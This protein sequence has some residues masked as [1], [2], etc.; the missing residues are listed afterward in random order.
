MKALLIPNTIFHVYTHAV[1]SDNLFRD[2]DDYI[3]FLTTLP[4]HTRY[5]CDIQ[6]YCLM[7]NHFHLLIRICSKSELLERALFEDVKRINRIDKTRFMTDEELGR[8]L[9][10]CLGRAFSSHSQYVNKRY[11][12]M[13]NLFISNFKRK[14]ITD[15]EY[16]RNV[17]K[18]IHMNPV[19]HG[20]E[21]SPLNWAFSSYSYMRF[22]P[23]K[24]RED[25]D[26]LR[27][28]GGHSSFI[29]AHEDFKSGAGFSPD[30]NNKPIKKKDNEEDA[31]E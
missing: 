23:E 22:M 29:A 24:H 28:F 20:F 11:E 9:S 26:I 4:Y 8:F 16:H 13:G 31:N 30:Y 14:V 27:L 21:V 1:G 2:P 6:A 10:G 18:Y 7:P 17:V 15:E 12:R 5:F 25:D 19:N 3:R